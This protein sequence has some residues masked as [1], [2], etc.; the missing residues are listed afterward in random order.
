MALD[1]LAGCG[2]ST[3]ATQQYALA[4]AQPT[5]LPT[6]HI[7]GVVDRVQFTAPEEF[8]GPS[9]DAEVA[10]VVVGAHGNARWN[11]PDG[12]RPPIATYGEIIRQGYY[13]YTLV[14]FS[15]F[16]PL[17]VHELPPG[18]TFMTIGGQVG[19]DSYRMDGYPQLQ[20]V[21]GHYIVIITAPAPR[22]D[23][24]PADTLLI[25]YA[26]PSNASGKIIIQ[27]A[28]DPNE[29][30]PGVPQPEISVA[31]TDLKAILARCA[32]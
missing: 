18:S 14:T 25:S 7:E 1:A 21:G 2:Q 22:K 28:G 26:F 8:C 17:R 27:Q 9:L 20:G 16:T 10:E 11:T 30:G 6:V 4:K 32:T 31:L 15:S 24:T 3:T 12:K 29:P 5:P 13:I 19:Q 23:M